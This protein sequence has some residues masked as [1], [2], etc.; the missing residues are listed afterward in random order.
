MDDADQIKNALKMLRAMKQSEF[1][2][3]GVTVKFN[4]YLPFQKKTEFTRNAEKMAVAARV[5]PKVRGVEDILR[6]FDLPRTVSLITRQ[7]DGR[8]PLTTILAVTRKR[9]G[10]TPETR[11]MSLD[12]YPIQE[13]AANQTTRCIPAL[14]EQR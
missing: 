12:I 5:H 13:D 14:K 1:K 6:K 10:Q 7:A 11:G 8:N 3:D 9:R 4:G 2:E